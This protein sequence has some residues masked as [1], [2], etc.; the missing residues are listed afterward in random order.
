MTRPLH[1]SINSPLGPTISSKALNSGWIK[2]LRNA[3]IE[4]SICSVNTGSSITIRMREAVLIKIIVIEC[5]LEDIAGK[6]LGS[7]IPG[8][9]RKCCVRLKI[10]NAFSA[11]S[12]SPVANEYSAIAIAAKPSENT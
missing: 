9:S 1:V 5:P 6:Y 10:S 4:A 7:S 8:V 3:A 2:Y 12:F 11:Y